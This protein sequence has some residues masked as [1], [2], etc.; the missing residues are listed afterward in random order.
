MTIGTSG[1]VRVASSKPLPNTEAM[2]FSYILDKQ[3]YIC[4]GPINNGG[5]A[6]NGG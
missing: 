2:I 5:V 6:C 4:G 3:T 1:A